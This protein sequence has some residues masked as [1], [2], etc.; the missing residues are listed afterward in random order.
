MGAGRTR[1]KESRSV[2]DIIGD[3]H[4]H[5]E[6]LQALLLKLGYRER[7]GA[8]RH[9]T[10]TAIFVGD[11]IDGGPHQIETVRLVRGMVEAG[12]ARITLGN[13]EYNA[14]LWA[15]YHPERPGEFMRPHTPR[16]A[17]STTCFLLLRAKGLTSI[18]NACASSRAFPFGSI[19]PA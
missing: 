12:A 6:A 11:L 3:V 5:V 18:A 7:N 8:W 15:T 16:T 4:G 2:Y 10:R 1:R 13:H 17:A 9:P 14:L 19:S